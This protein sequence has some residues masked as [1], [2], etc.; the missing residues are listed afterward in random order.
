MP[1]TFPLE[2]APVAVRI[3]RG[4]RNL[5]AAL[6]TA[7]VAGVTVTAA[8]PTSA[9]QAPPGQTGSVWAQ[10][11]NPDGTTTVSLYRAPV[12]VSATQLYASLRETGVT[13]LV[14]PSGPQPLAAGACSYGTASALQNGACPPVRWR[15]NGF[16][17]PQV[18]FRDHT[19]AAW[20]VT[21]SV[22]EWHKA[23]GADSY[24]IYRTS[25]CPAASTGRHC[26]N[27]LSGNY[28]FTGPSR[29]T[30]TYDSSRYLVDGSVEIR[31]NHH[32]SNPNENRTVVCL[33]LGTALGVGQNSAS[34]SCMY[35]YTVS[36]PEPRLPNS[37]DYNLI[38]YVLYPD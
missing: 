8:T 16:G 34:N 5:V 30:M 35:P 12:G 27:V 19:S 11:V 18:Y 23:V 20:P 13:G 17:D 9:A 33:N 29:I 22:S 3:P 15:K 31:L 14:D 2:G 24:Y 26:V 10:Q 36:G 37:S 25:A 38:R 21:A 28:G 6:V 4:A 7:V 1:L 32:Y